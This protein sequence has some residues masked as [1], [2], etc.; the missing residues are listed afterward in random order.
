LTSAALP[1]S[2]T[3]DRR[4]MG[5]PL[6]LTLVGHPADEAERAWSLASDEF[7]AAEQALSR[8]RDSSD[9]S[10]I[11]RLAGTGRVVIVDRRLSAALVAADRAG[12]LTDGRFD[13]RVLGDL[14]RLG[15]RGAALTWPD[16]PADPPAG[17]APPAAGTSRWLTVDPSSS[18]VAVARPVDLGGIGKGLALR[19][20]WRRIVRAGCLEGG[21]GALLEAG[22]DLVAGGGAP[23]AGPWIVAI[24]DPTGGAEPLAMIGVERGAVTTSSTLVQRWSSGDGRQVHHL[25]D[26]ATGE[27]GGAGLLSVTVAGPDPAWSEVWS[28]TLFLSGIAGIAALARARGLAAWWVD[29]AGRLEMTAAARHRTSWVAAED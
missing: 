19:W 6:R 26:P 2:L 16:T 18:A 29:A 28:K 17:G 13:A 14:E 11:N 25:I 10:A 12:R 1:T 21:G 9:L 27:P 22:G 15:Y 5:S 3:F 7:E 23:Q 20:A 4:A 8:F 24:E